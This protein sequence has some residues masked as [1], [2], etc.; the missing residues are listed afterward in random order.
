MKQTHLDIRLPVGRQSNCNLF[1][2]QRFQR[3]KNYTIFFDFDI[4][5]LFLF[6]YVCVCAN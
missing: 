6:G 2:Q 4:L 3:Q 5:K 1:E